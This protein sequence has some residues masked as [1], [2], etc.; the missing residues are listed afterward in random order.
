MLIKNVESGH[1]LPCSDLLAKVTGY[2][3][4]QGLSYMAFIVWKQ[5]LSIF[6]LSFY[7][8]RLWNL[9]FSTST[10]MITWGGRTSFLSSGLKTMTGTWEVCD[11]MLYTASQ[12]FKHLLVCLK[13]GEKECNQRN[14]D[15][16]SNQVMAHIYLYIVVCQKILAF[17]RLKFHF[18]FQTIPQ[19]RIVRSVL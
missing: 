15:F 3:V 18:L 1:P 13:E 5:S 6:L 9:L 2:Y 7:H 17:F 16:F 10:E 19:H 4:H 12:R 14:Y 11:L 8:E